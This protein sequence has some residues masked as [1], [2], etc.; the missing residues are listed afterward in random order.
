MP[1]DITPSALAAGTPEGSHQADGKGTASEVMSLEEMNKHLGKDFKDR[2]S[3]LKAIKDTFSFVGSTGQIKQ[4]LNELKDQGLSEEEVFNRL[5]NFDQGSKKTDSA[6]PEDVQKRISRLE[7]ENFY[8]VH[9][10][11]KEYANVLSGLRT[12]TGLSLSDLVASDTYKSVFEKL[13][14]HDQAAD[15]KRVLESSPRLG[16]VRDKMKEAREAS[17]SNPKVARGMAVGAVLDA[18]ES[19]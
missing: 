12:S 1:E 13:S 10:Q 14:A 19:K 5:K 15:Q 3:A 17:E 11:F 16:R 2:D 7:D 9:P 6:I 8:A 4:R 18:F